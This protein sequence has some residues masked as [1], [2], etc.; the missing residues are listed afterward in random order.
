MITAADRSRYGSMVCDLENDCTHGSNGLTKTV[1]DAYSYIV[2]Y[3]PAQK[4]KGVY[5]H[6]PKSWIILDTGSTANIFCNRNLLRDTHETDEW[7][8]LNCN[9]GQSTTNIQGTLLS[10]DIVWFSEKGSTN[11]LSFAILAGKYKITYNK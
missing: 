5:I 1:A 10:F 9:S 3:L 2:N 6:I 4:A 7:L 8:D 11:I